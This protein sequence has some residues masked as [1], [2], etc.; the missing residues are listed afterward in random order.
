MKRD[1]VIIVGGGVSGLA[2]GCYLQM[3]GY[4]TRILEM[5]RATG[6]VSVSW[7]R[8]G[9]TFD[10]AMNW[11]AGS[12]P[13]LNFHDVLREFVD[14]SRYAYLEP[15]AGQRPRIARPWSGRWS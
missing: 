13:P 7:K 9:Y 14:M 11:L 1:E 5:G 3:N 4:R 10:P 8:G 6:G 12:A 15:L 2:T